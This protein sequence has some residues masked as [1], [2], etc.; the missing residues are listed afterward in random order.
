MIQQGTVMSDFTENTQLNQQLTEASIQA[1]NA[2]ICFLRQLDPSP[3]ATFNIEHYT[4]LPKGENKPK[5]DT[6]GGRYANLNVAEVEALLPKLHAIN[7]KGAGIFVARNQCTGHRSELN[8]SHIRGVHAD[9][10]DVT[11]AQLDAVMAVLQPSMVVQSSGP[12]R[13]QLYWQLVEGETL[14]KAETKAINQCFAEYHGADS[15][16]VD[17]S[18]LLRLPGFKHMKYRADGKTPTVTATVYGHTYTADQIRQAFT[19]SQTGGPAAKQSINI[20]TTTYVTQELTPQLSTAALSIATAYPHLWAGDWQNAI[21]PSGEIGYPSRSEADLALAG[22][23]VRACQKS[24]IDADSLGGAVDAVFC[25]SPL[26]QTGKWVD[27][28]DYRAR[29]INKALSSSYPLSAGSAHEGLVLES[30]GDIRNAKAFAQIARGHFLYVATRDRWL[31][32]LQQKWNV[33]EK[34]EH[35]AMAKDVCGQILNAAG[36]VFG[37]DQERG[38]RLLQEAMAAHN[39][40]RITA[41]LKLTV[42]EPE[43]AT[44][45]RELDRD[46]YLLGVRNG[47]IDLRT[48]LH[49][50]NQPEMRITR[51]CNAGFAEDATCPQW[52]RFLDQI[53]IN[54]T[55]TI[56]CVQRLLGCTL[57]GLATE[58]ILII[59][60]GHGSNGKSVFSNVVHKIMGGYSITAPPSLLAARRQD[61]TGPRNDLAALVGARYVSI[62]EMQAGDRLDEQVVKM[63]AGREPISARFLHQEF[64]EFTP[65]FTPWLRTNHKP[66]IT[67]LDDGIW[68]RLVLLPFGRKFTGD[69]KD[70]ALEQK[71]LDEQDAILMWMV[72]GAKLYLQDG[73][74]LSPRMRSELGIYRSESDLLGEFLSDQTRPDPTGKANQGTLYKSYREWCEESGV[75]PLSKKTFTQR[76][77]ERGYPEGKSGKNRFYCGLVCGPPLPS[78]TQDGVDRIEGISGICLHGNL[79]LEKTPNSPSSCPTCPPPICAEGAG[80]V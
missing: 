31:Q 58:E 42:S 50:F 9:M 49:Y 21:R 61:D 14:T 35:V 24:G 69:E 45:D 7:E 46:P 3:D 78:S 6:L 72:E 34:D 23:I 20:Q 62:N 64:F 11:E 37:Q 57:L 36:S 71:L 29:T 19:P 54:D 56:E 41:M 27:R 51:Y 1:S 26:G 22:H 47:V 70:P 25:S 43:M 63:L 77:A 40:S 12:T 60:Y 48:G 39:L 28:D 17:V 13:Y 74:K 38:K 65:S 16:A 44:T 10:D 75:R 76:L 33:C 53:F 80:H 30:H 55:E 8:V 18:R 15:A 32:W 67:G 79:S 68:R 73:I 59:C 52:L 5:P 66:I 4:D 2:A